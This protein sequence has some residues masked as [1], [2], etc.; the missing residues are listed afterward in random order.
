[1]ASSLNFAEFAQRRFIT[2]DSKEY[3][4]FCKD[5]FSIFDLNGDD[6]IEPYE[7]E[8]AYKFN[9]AGAELN[10]LIEKNDLGGKGITWKSLDLLDLVK[11]SKEGKIQLNE[12]GNIERDAFNSW[13]TTAL[14]E[15]KSLDSSLE[16][17]QVEHE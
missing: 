13:L 12:S 6:V 1:M 7:V 14:E 11:A 8:E 16:G 3:D 2:T 17:A 15:F 5:A 10:R 9:S 4:T